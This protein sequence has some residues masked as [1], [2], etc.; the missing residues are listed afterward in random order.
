MAAGLTDFGK[1]AVER[2]EQLGMLVD[3]SHLSDGG[4]WDVS[5][6]CKGPFVASHSNCRALN[7]HPRSL[8]DEM[9]RTLAEHGGVAGLNFAPEFLNGDI[10][11][12]DS[13]VEDMV[14][15]LRHRINVGGE[16]CAA[17]GSDLDGIGGR[18]EID[19]SAAMPRPAPFVCVEFSAA[20]TAALVFF[21]PKRSAS[22]SPALCRITV[23]PSSAPWDTMLVHWATQCM[24]EESSKVALR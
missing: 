18:L 14:T 19:S 21:L 3:V 17:L 7:P 24:E 2:M 6:L 10:T 11:C 9:L 4:F 1:E 5:R 22:A 20:Y 16:D 12:Q 23:P 15:Q 8:T 13:R